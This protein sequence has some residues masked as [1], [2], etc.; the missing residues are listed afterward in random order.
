MTWLVSRAVLL[1][2]LGSATPEA[3][4]T[5]LVIEPGDA[6]LTT[7]VAFTTALLRRFPRLHV[8]TPADC[9]QEPTLAFAETKELPTGNESV[10]VTVVAVEGPRLVIEIV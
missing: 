3:T 9:E 8:T 7:M 2:E 6:D 10:S 4:L 1:P 5:V